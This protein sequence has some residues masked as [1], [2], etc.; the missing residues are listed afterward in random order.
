MTDEK[1]DK[2]A[3]LIRL[4]EG[5]HGFQERFY[6]RDPTFFEDL[7]GSGQKPRVL[8]VACSDSRSDPA[9]LTAAQPGDL[10]IVRNVAAIVPPYAADGRHHGTS[11]AIEY[12]VKALGVDH[13]VIL[14][15]SNCGGLRAMADGLAPEMGEFEFVTP[16]VGIVAS[17]RSAGDAA[18]ADAP[19]QRA[20]LIEQAAVSISI[21]NLMSYPWIAERTKAG[22]LAVHGWYFDMRLGALMAL[23]AEKKEFRRIHPGAAPKPAYG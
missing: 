14:G 5:F 3:T 9:I 10:F 6:D 20:R 15:H 13:V 22:R 4:I 19:R 12:G 21:A 17:A 11:S 23:D 16:W 18:P 8:V 1:S 2:N 7:I